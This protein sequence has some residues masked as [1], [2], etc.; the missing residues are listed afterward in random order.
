MVKLLKAKD[1]GRDIECYPLAK[2]IYE[3]QEEVVT[4]H[5]SFFRK[6]KTTEYVSKDV[7]VYLVYVPEEEIIIYLYEDEIIEPMDEFTK[8][9]VKSKDF[10]S[11]LPEEYNP[12]DFLVRGFYGEKFIIERNEFMSLWEEM[13]AEEYLEILSQEKPE[14]FEDEEDEEE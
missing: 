10:V 11:H 4:E 8:N 2:F 12:S 13:E 14:L 1:Q 3:E 9:W 5:K 6:W 7:P